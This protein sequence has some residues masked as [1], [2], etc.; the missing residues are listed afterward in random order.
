[1]PKYIT[2]NSNFQPDLKS[3]LFNKEK[4]ET[5]NLANKQEHRMNRKLS[6]I[7]T[8]QNIKLI[9][10]LQSNTFRNLLRKYFT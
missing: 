8:F 4:Q 10:H 3:F 6:A 9:L 7:N 2:E 1:M 5:H